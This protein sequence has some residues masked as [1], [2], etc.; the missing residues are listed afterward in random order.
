VLHRPLFGAEIGPLSMID[1][2]TAHSRLSC[3]R[4]RATRAPSRKAN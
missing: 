1:T 4:G 3:C 2:T